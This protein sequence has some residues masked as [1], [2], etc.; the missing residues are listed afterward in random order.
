[1]K[2]MYKREKIDVGL[3]P[4]SIASTNKTGG[5]FGMQMYRKALAIL[6][7]GAMA[8]TNTAKIELLQAKDNIGTDAKA[9]DGASAI[10]TASGA[11]TSG[12][13]FIE[14]DVSSLDLTNGF[15]YVAAR[16][17]TNATLVSGVTLLRGDGRFE[18]EQDVQAYASV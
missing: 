16:V 12:C 10:I 17:T 7:T 6:S 8:D 14:I 2:P 13:A 11:L 1:M 9:I 4:Q 18:A 15:E 3:A 5:Y